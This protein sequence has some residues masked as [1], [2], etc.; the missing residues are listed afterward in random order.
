[1]RL[2]GPI[3][4]SDIRHTLSVLCARARVPGARTIVHLKNYMHNCRPD[5]TQLE[6]THPLKTFKQKYMKPKKTQLAYAIS[7]AIIASSAEG[8]S[9]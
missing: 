2:F 8:A 7:I 3:G 1:M 9:K 4:F 5:S 6:A